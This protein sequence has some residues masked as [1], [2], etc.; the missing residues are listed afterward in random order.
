VGDVWIGLPHGERPRLNVADGKS[1]RDPVNETKPALFSAANND[2]F[3]GNARAGIFAAITVDLGD[4][5][6]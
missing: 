2:R 6:E 4:S 5:R 1:D 3:V